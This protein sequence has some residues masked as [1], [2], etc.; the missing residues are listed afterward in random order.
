M[1]RI[2]SAV[3]VVASL[4]LLASGAAAQDAASPTDTEVTNRLSFIQGALDGGKKAA[5]FWWY[6]WFGGYSA[7]TVGQLAVYSGSDNEKQRQDMLVGSVTTGLGAAGV[8]VFPLEAGRFASRLRTIPAATPEERRSKLASAE[9][10][11]RQAAAQ[12]SFGRSWKAQ[13]LATAVNLAA[14]LTIWLHYNRP[15]QDGLVTFAIGQLISEAQIFSQPMKAVRDL[16]EYDR[17][18]D[19]DRVGSVPDTRHTWYVSVYPAGIIVGCRF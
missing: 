12:E 7:A 9:S 1:K 11:L 18:T 8:V 13:A 14:G 15:A 10:F 4:F 5:D 6:G 16:Q 2:V 17:R 3:A 19:F